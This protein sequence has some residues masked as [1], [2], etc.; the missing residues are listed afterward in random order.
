MTD[1]IELRNMRF[2]GRHGVYEHERRTDQPFEVDVELHLDLAPAGR[3]D[4]LALTVDYGQVHAICRR[5]IEGPSHQL[6]ESLG[7]RIAEA[8]L[9]AHRVR[10]VVVRVRKPAVDLGGPLD[11]AG[12]EI[13]R[14]RRRRRWRGTLHGL[15]ASALRA[16]RSGG[17]SSRRED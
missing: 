12:V 2:R 13:T 5:I 15:S 11:W 6:L 16:S 1:R 4:D 8:I 17:A 14:T 7:E 9:D 3:T 10:E